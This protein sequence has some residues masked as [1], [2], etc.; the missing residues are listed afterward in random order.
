[1]KQVDNF[2]VSCEDRSPEKDIFNAINAKMT[3]EI[4]ELGLISRFNGMDVQQTQ[5]YIKLSNA[6]YINKILKNHPWLQDEKP[7]ATFPI[8]M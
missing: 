6:V 3:I 7:A 5:H 2:C 8:P 1:M 4:K